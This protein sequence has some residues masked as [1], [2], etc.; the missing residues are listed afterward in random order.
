MQHLATLGNFL[1]SLLACLSTRL[2]APL[3][4]RVQ[5]SGVTSGLS[6]KVTVNTT[7]STSCS[8]PSGPYPPLSSHSN[9]AGRTLA[10]TVT[11]R[12]GTG[13]GVTSS[14]LIT[15]RRPI[16]FPS[17]VPAWR[18]VSSAAPVRVASSL[19]G[20]LHTSSS[21]SR[22]GGERKRHTNDTRGRSG[23]GI[24][25]GQRQRELQARR[26]C[27]NQEGAARAATGHAATEH[28]ATCTDHIEHHMAHA[29]QKKTPH[30]A[31]KKRK[32]ERN[33]IHSTSRYPLQGPNLCT[34]HHPT[35]RK[36]I[37]HINPKRSTP[38]LHEFIE[39]KDVFFIKLH[40][41]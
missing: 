5:H 1:A 15:P 11:G 8:A 12:A 20:R 29:A 7:S 18:P 16:A 28:A 14:P 6:V 31:Q 2:A 34:P 24:I 33:K 30:T 26:G 4:T 41:P 9:D 39:A 21:V 36:E 10:A 38:N 17:L 13:A 23:E 27:D 35:L 19:L 37:L 22:V 25:A 40:R 3:A 32:A